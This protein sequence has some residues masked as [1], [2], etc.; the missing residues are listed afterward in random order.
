[1]PR[2]KA[3]TS[4]L[5]QVL[6]KSIEVPPVQYPVLFMEK[7][8]AEAD[9]KVFKQL[10]EQSAYIRAEREKK[11]RALLSFYNLHPGEEDV[12]YVLSLKMACDHIPGFKVIEKKARGPKQR[13]NPAVLYLLWFEV[14]KKTK[15]R[16]TAHAACAQ[17]AKRQPWLTLIKSTTKGA[18]N[19]QTLYWW[20]D[21]AKSSAFVQWVENACKAM[22]S[23]AAQDAT[24]REC[25]DVLRR[26][27]AEID[28]AMKLL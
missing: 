21:K 15:G 24:R 19:H 3:Q 28:P 22:P 23:S 7:S 5:P 16:V 18:K 6:R 11:L 12:W 26:R 1:M 27:L 14:R 13:W 8:D 17:L 4:E 2:K 9:E 25:Y 20:Y 10:E